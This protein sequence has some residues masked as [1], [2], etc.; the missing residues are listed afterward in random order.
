MGS[1]ADALRAMVVEI[2]N[3][4]DQHVVVG[5]DG[6]TVAEDGVFLRLPGNSMAGPY[7]GLA[8]AARVLAAQRAPAGKGGGGS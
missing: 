7:A 4:L 1:A 8:E 6:Q 5:D 3:E 2:L